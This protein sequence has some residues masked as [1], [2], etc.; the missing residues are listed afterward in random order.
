MVW[1]ELVTLA[2]SKIST[3]S[4][5]ASLQ[6]HPN[7]SMRLRKFLL[8]IFSRSFSEP[9]GGSSSSSCPDGD[10]ERVALQ[11]GVHKLKLQ[12]QIYDESRDLPYLRILFSLLLVLSQ[13]LRIIVWLL[14]VGPRSVL[15]RV[16]FSIL[17]FI[18]SRPL[19]VCLMGTQGLCKIILGRMIIVQ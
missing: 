2:I 1:R 15:G 9:R 8:L 13:E 19:P 16:C 6:N 11:E 3:M 7:E 12:T 17:P 14:K 4:L 10:A 5:V 18:T